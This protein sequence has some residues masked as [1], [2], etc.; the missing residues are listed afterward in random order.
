L[1]SAAVL[2]HGG[3]DVYIHVHATGGSGLCSM[4]VA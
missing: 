3:A 1:G 2:D 4:I